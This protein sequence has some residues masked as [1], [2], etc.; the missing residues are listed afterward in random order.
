MKLLLSLL[1]VFVSA[2]TLTSAQNLAE[3]AGTN[4]FTTL[5]A[6]VTASRL[7]FAVVNP[8]SELSKF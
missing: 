3:V 8:A 7:A 6:A 2:T 1:S 4:G 5:V